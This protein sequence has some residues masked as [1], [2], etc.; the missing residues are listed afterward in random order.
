MRRIAE[1]GRL[2]IPEDRA[3]TLVHA[4]GCG[5]T[6]ALIATPE[7][8]R[9]PQLS[10]TAREAVIAAITTD[11]PATAAP[12]PVA[13]AVALRAALPQTDAPSI[14]HGTADEFGEPPRSTSA[15]TECSREG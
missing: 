13:A 4:A 2:R 12:G 1:A 3:A 14:P 5:T 10:A 6:L 11:T 8:H 15:A 9:D 7:D